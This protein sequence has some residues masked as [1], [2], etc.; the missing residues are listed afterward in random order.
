M[1]T[2]DEIKTAECA[3]IMLVQEQR[4]RDAAINFAKQ[5]YAGYRSQRKMRPM[6]YGQPYRTEL[7]VSCLVFRKFLRSIL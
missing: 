1:R 7:I 3:R 4:G 2:I 6:K 5:T